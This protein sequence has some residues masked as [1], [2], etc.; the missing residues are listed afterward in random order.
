MSDVSEETK[1]IQM[2]YASAATVP[3]NADQLETL[4]E[5]A[6]VNNASLGVTGVLLFKDETFF[7]VLE[8]EPDHVQ[9]IYDKIELD[10]RHGNVLLLAKNAIT[11]RNFGEWSMGF[12]RDQEK[13]EQL[14]G[15]V[16]FF[17]R[18][19]GSTFIDLHGDAQRISQILDGFRRGRWR[20][21]ATEQLA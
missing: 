3:F 21:Q 6:R 14:P 19:P 10:A 20:R 15:F 5:R 12:V 17:A 11:E 18:Q 7:Q 2:I 8:G 4:L 13:L 1:L 9:A 16:D